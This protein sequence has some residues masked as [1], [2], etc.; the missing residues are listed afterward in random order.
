MGGYSMIARDTAA[1]LGHF[2]YHD[3]Q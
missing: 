3:M 1:I 2:W